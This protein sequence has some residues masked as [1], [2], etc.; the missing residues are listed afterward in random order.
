MST[1]T[2]VDTLGIQNFVFASNRLRDVVG[3][4]EL[5]HQATSRQ[6]WVEQLGYQNQVIVGAGGNLLLRFDD[7]GQ[8]RNFAAQFSRKMLDEAPGLEVALV[9]H[10]YL[11]GQLAKAIQE[12]QIKIENHKLERL[13]S[14]PLLGLGITTMCR[15]TRRPA[16]EWDDAEGA[17][18]AESIAKRRSDSNQAQTRWL[19]FFPCSYQNFQEGKGR[20]VELAFP[21]ELDDL[22]RSRG[23]TS[24]MG[25]VHIDGNGIGQ[26]LKTWLDKCVQNGSDDET[27]RN[28]YRSLSKKLDGLAEEV[29]RMLL[30]HIIDAIK[31]QAQ[32]Y[33]LGS[34]V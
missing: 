14:V 33:V 17:P 15:E 16:A 26:K 10:E 27:V 3:G 30:N 8:A 32:E 4:S 2:F 23:D 12:I 6:G 13:P 1:L 9:Y 22:G 28:A 34:D 24:L 29:F 25:V 21:L 5:V 20:P 11:D 19:K 31:Y 18:I 7:H